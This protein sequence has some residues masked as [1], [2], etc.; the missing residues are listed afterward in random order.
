[1]IRSRIVRTGG[2]VQVGSTLLTL[3]CS[4]DGLAS[5]SRGMVHESD[6]AWFLRFAGRTIFGALRGTLSVVTALLG[7][8]IGSPMGVIAILILAYVFW[9]PFHGWVNGLVGA[10]YRNVIGTVLQKILS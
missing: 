8:V 7:R 4:P 3:E 2:C 9:R 5:R 1:M 6:F 10:A